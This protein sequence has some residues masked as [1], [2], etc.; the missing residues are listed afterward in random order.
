[1]KPKAEA[2]PEHVAPVARPEPVFDPNDGVAVFEIT[3][4]PSGEIIDAVL[5]RSSGSAQYDADA[6]RAI[7]KMSPLPR[8]R[9]EDFQRVRMM[10]FRQPT[11]TPEP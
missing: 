5:R 8:G 1:M 2:K 7:I 9:A 6:R 10:R 11:L 3:Q 4:L